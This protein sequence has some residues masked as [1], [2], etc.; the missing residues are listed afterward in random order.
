MNKL[1]LSLIALAVLAIT[2]CSTVR[3][4]GSVEMKDAPVV[5]GTMTKEINTLPAPDGPPISVAI[6]GFKDLTGQRKPSQTLSLFSTAVTQGAEAY[7][8][9]TMPVSYTHLT[10]PTNREV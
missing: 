9:K 4:M 6:Y 2:G 5:S 8:I 1:K 10:L 3:P 7:L